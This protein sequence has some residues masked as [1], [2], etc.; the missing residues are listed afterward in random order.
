MRFLKAVLLCLLFS[1]IATAATIQG[2]VYDFSLDLISGVI[3]EVNTTPNQKMVAKD[4]FYSFDV[5]K[6][7]YRISA[8][9]RDDSFRIE[10]DIEVSSD[11]KY[12][13]DLIL[14]PTLDAEQDILEIENQEAV[15]DDVPLIEDALYEQ[16]RS[17]LGWVSWIILFIIL[18]FLIYKLSSKKQEKEERKTGRVHKVAVSED[19]QK[20][21]SII[22][23]EGGRTTQ[24]E[25]RKRLPVSEAKVSLMLDE[26][27]HKGLIKR[28]RKG[29]A[30][31]IVKQ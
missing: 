12:N 4:A 3:V 7:S 30:N 27:E 25:I 6:G 2:S 13:L 20:V 5:P 14:L 21:L 10:E 22:D 19:L 8:S 28:I 9:T 26:L 23:E 15:V 1:N 11:G 16:P 18:G 29:R 24:K 17:A 31:I